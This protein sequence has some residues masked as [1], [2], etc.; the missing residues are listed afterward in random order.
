M[1]ERALDILTLLADYPQGL[2]IS[3]VARR[4]ELPKSAVHRLLTSL[5]GSGLAVQDEYSQRYRLTV[6]LAAI[7]FRFLAA[8]GITEICQP[9]LDRLATRTGELVRLALLENDA[10]IWIAKAQGSFS[11]L[12]YDPD[13]GKV[14]VLHATASG[15]AWLA[16][17]DEA[18]ATALVKTNGFIVPSRFGQPVVRDEAS[19]HAELA[20]TRKRGWGTSIEEGEPGTCAV[21]CAIL[22]PQSRL[23]IGTVSVAG[24]VA[25]LT[26]ERI[27]AI[28][29]DVQATA[30][31][32]A[33]LWPSRKVM[34]AT[35]GLTPLNAS[36]G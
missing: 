9:S 36:N 1:I 29:P 27:A 11:G 7:G 5:V 18:Y 20:M 26:L 8:S 34:Q 13:M 35:M 17:L 10:L 31:E 16:T 14:V 24:P 12:R 30:A 4:L 22:D 19:L 25:R 2:P 28:A 23:A 3:D 6:K 32:I 15:K 21:A 33:D